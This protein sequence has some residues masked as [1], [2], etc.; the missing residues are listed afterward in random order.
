MKKFLML[1][2]L[3]VLLLGAC[4]GEGNDQQAIEE[5]QSSLVTVYRSPT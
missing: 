4:T 1:G 5:E 2:L 3:A